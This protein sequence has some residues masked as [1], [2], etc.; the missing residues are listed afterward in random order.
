MV[1]KSRLYYRMSFTV[2]LF[3]LL[4]F[5]PIWVF[6]FSISML[7]LPDHLLLFAGLHLIVGGLIIQQYRTGTATAL[8]AVNAAPL[9]DEVLNQRLHALAE[10]MGVPTPILMI[11][12]F[13]EANAF[14]A[15]RKGNGTIVLSDILLSTL[16]IDE[17]EAV[18]AH[19]LSHL[20]TR[21]T[22]LMMFGETLDYAIYQAKYTL[23]DE[24]EGLAGAIVVIAAFIIGG[25]LRLLI[26]PP[27][28]LI[29]RKRE[30]LADADAAET[31]DAS[32]LTSAL[33]VAAAVNAD[34]EPH[35]ATEA[36]SS[37]CMY[38]TS[39]ALLDR[40]L[41]T[42]PPVEERIAYLKKHFG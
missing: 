41:G 18:M 27:L 3:G 10:E 30:F 23:L 25:F 39:S 9:E 33:E 1:S 26:V 29:S 20:G 13:G 8:R 36:V 4:F 5:L 11:G 21:D 37:L 2:A 35:P 6:W 32:S 31:T 7:R 42:H 40:V 17:I 38:S 16:D 24:I 15:G 19:E 28:R 12:R 34:V 22:T 14:A